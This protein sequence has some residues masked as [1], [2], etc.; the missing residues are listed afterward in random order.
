MTNRST[1]SDIEIKTAMTPGDLAEVRGLFS[2]YGADIPRAHCLRG[3]DDEVAGLSGACGP[4]AG[5]LLL[6]TAAAKRLGAAACGR[7]HRALRK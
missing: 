6:M 7:R 2:E 5:C 1:G 4:P 3:F